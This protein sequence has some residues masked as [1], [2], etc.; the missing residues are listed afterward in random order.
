MP[1]MPYMPPQ[2][3]GLA[4]LR[5][6]ES[7]ALV[8]MREAALTLEAADMDPQALASIVNA[9]ARPHV[10][11]ALETLPLFEHMATQAL[12]ICHMPYLPYICHMPYLPYMSYALSD[13]WRRRRWRSRR[14]PTTR[15]RWR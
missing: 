9:F 8:V 4:S 5:Y 15:R 2:V 3:N 11:Q 7:P 12:L 13:T 6:V 10:M 1:Y 14:R